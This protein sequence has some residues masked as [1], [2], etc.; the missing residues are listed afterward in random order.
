MATASGGI[1]VI[2]DQCRFATELGLD[3]KILCESP[4]VYPLLPHTFEQAIRSEQTF[5]DEDFIVL[6]E[7]LAPMLVPLFAKQRLVVLNQNAYLTFDSQPTDRGPLKEHCYDHPAV[8]AI[9]CVSADSQSYLEMAFPEKKILR[10]TLYLS[11]IEFAYGKKSRDFLLAYMPRKNASHAVQVLSLL[12]RRNK[13]EA[14]KICAIDGLRPSEVADRLQRSVLF[15]SF[16]CPEGLPYPVLEALA[17]GCYVVGYTGQGGA[18]L[19][20]SQWSRAIPVYDIRAFVLAVEAAIGAYYC[21]PNIYV[22]A[23]AAARDFVVTS[24][25]AARARHSAKELWTQLGA[26]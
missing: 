25:S 6:P 14:D 16:G 12:T 18:E 7:Y 17:S 1:R 2:L 19:F 13:I 5:F 4:V 15:L 26:L 24:F 21:D 23:G 10:A 9:V 20:S 22:Q 11:E 3:A 8:K